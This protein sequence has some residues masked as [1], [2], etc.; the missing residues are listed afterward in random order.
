MKNKIIILFVSVFSSLFLF[1]SNVL[2]NTYNYTIPTPLTNLTES[3]INNMITLINNTGMNY[4]YYFIKYTTDTSNPYT[5]FTIQ[6]PYIDTDYSI[7]YGNCR[8]YV[9]S[10]DFSTL[11]QA[12]RNFNCGYAYM[13]SYISLLPQF[14]NTNYIIYSNFNFNYPNSDSTFNYTYIDKTFSQPSTDNLKFYTIA[15]IR[16]WYYTDPHKTLTDFVSLVIDRLNYITEYFS[17]N[18]I[19]LSIFVIF[20][21]YFSILLVRRFI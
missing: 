4:S 19:Y 10:N 6:N 11:T 1:S 7:K 16:E 13:G 21:F 8:Q 9:F 5:V 18:Y 15:D 3:N 2:A 12:T 14:A 20:L 17:S